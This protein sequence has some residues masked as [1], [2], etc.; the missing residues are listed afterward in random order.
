MRSYL[1]QAITICNAELQHEGSRLGRLED[2][3]SNPRRV[4]NYCPGPVAAMIE[5]WPIVN[6][7]LLCSKYAFLRRWGIEIPNNCS[8]VLKPI[9][10]FD[11]HWE[12]FFS[13]FQSSGW[14]LCHQKWL[15]QFCWIGAT[16]FS[17]LRSIH[18]SFIPTFNYGEDECRKPIFS[19]AN[20]EKKKSLKSFRDCQF[21]D[22]H[23]LVLS[24]I[25]SLWV[26]WRVVKLRPKSSPKSW[27]LDDGNFDHKP[28]YWAHEHFWVQRSALR[29]FRVSLV[30]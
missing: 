26:C 16:K 25:S 15:W 7:F 21:W 5:K 4:S 2:W 17:G 8:I 22:L 29:I 3:N 20:I 12:H 14:P 19:A 27:Q 6:L 28:Q 13:L 23:L 10:I 9:F 18:T 30:K 1:N 24:I 11:A